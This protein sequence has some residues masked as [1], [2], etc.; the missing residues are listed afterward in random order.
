M[1]HPSRKSR[2]GSLQTF[3]PLQED[4]PFLGIGGYGIVFQDRD[5]AIKLLHDTDKCQELLHE[6][7]I[8]Q[9]SRK[10]LKTTDIKVPRILDISNYPVQYKTKT[11]L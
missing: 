5:T 9:L 7:N 3:F 10:V 2:K 1:R 8:Q 6:A 4:S 11:Y